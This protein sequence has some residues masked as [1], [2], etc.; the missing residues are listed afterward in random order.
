MAE[1]I[2]EQE[3]TMVNDCE[4]VRGLDANGNSIK[5][6]KSEL[7]KVIN[8]IIGSVTY[9]TLYLKENGYGFLL[10]HKIVGLGCV[11]FDVIQDFFGFGDGINAVCVSVM[12]ELG[13]NAVPRFKVTTTGG[14]SHPMDNKQC[15]IAYKIEAN[16]LCI[17]SPCH[18]N[19]GLTIIEYFKYGS[20]Q[21]LS[22]SSIEVAN[23][24]SIPI[25]GN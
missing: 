9:R 21:L 5:I 22:E 16:T 2:R 6:S 17:Y 10:T 3:L 4:W 23:H 24:N 20:V 13:A 25:T 8:S 11:R 12:A 18:N 19:Y 7:A 14:M 1:D 15:S